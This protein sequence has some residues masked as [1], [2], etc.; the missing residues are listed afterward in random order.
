MILIQL[1]MHLLLGEFLKTLRS[2][3]EALEPEVWQSL[4]FSVALSANTKHLRLKNVF[5]SR[6]TMFPF[7]SFQLS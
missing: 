6:D 7:L 5:T 1:I 3:K 2:I 4:K